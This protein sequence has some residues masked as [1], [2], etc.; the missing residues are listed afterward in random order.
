MNGIEEVALQRGGCFG[1]CPAYEVAFFRDGSAWLHGKM[2][3]KRLGTYQ[4]T[5]S[6]ADFD[7]LASLIHRSGFFTWNDDYPPSSTCIP[8]YEL[9]VRHLDGGKR[10]RV[11]ADSPQPP[12][13]ERIA[14]SIDRIAEAVKWWSEDDA[15]RAMGRSPLGEGLASQDEGSSTTTA[16][17]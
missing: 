16:D 17:T 1:Q 2:F 15:N 6:V 12:G 7:R 3:V 5:F 10:V 8:P 9:T 14:R 4:G 13:F 11:W